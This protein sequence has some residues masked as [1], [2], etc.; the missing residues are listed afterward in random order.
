MSKRRKSRE[1]A[2]KTKLRDIFVARPFEGLVDEPEWVALRELVPAASAPLTLKPEIIEEYGDRPVTLSTVLPMAWPA[3]TRRDGRVFI[4]LQRHVQS[5]DVSRDLAV[6]ILSALRTKPGDTVAVPALP[7]EG[8]RLQDVLVDGPLEITLHEGF[9]YW[10]DAEQAQD[11]TVKASLERANA[12]IYPTVRLAAAKAAYWCRVAPDKSHI[13]WVLPEPE[14]KAL[15]ALARLSAAGELLLGED[16]KFAGMFRAH[17]VLVPVWDLPGEPEGAD[18]EAALADFAKRYA[19]TL[20]ADEPLDAA[21]RRAKQ[22]L[23]GRQLTLR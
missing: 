5:G 13:R 17:G 20:A 16:T 23:I 15:D 3:M 4:G 18:W 21:A 9:E 11:A 12:S 10:L 2:P 8:P 1:T 6:A 14:D 7:G 19:D 22:G